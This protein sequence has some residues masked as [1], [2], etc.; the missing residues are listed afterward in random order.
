MTGWAICG[1]NEIAEV[2]KCPIT[3][4]CNFNLIIAQK[5]L[6]RLWMPFHLSLLFDIPQTVHQYLHL[7]ANTQISQLLAS[8]IAKEKVR[9]NASGEL[10]ESIKKGSQMALFR[11]GGISAESERHRPWE[12][13]PTA[14]PIKSTYHRTSHCPSSTN[15][16]HLDFIDYSSRPWLT[17]LYS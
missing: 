7:Q 10:C 5:F 9:C 11:V 2:A 17:M 12:S 4:P 6:S 3:V 16:L 15:S 8:E 14:T 13:A 1:G